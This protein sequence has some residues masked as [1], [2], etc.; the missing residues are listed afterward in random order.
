MWARQFG[1]AS[2]DLPQRG[3]GGYITG[4]V[5]EGIFGV[6]ERGCNGTGNIVGLL[7]K[8]HVEGNE[9][10]TR[11]IKGRGDKGQGAEFTGGKRVRVSDAGVFVISNLSG[12]FARQFPVGSQSDQNECRTR[13]GRFYDQ[14][15]AHVRMYNFDGNVIW[16]RRFGSPLRYRTR[17]RAGRQQRLCFW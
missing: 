4:Q 1:T 10:W 3:G 8:Y 2:E 15:D 6:P 12:L 13:F 11:K 16:T 5:N 7:Q 14:L 9:I 17:C